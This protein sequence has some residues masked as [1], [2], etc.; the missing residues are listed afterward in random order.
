RGSR[1]HRRVARRDPPLRTRLHA[2]HG[3]AR[4]FRAPLPTASAGKDL[5]QEERR[6][7]RVKLSGQTWTSLGLS[8]LAMG[9]LLVLYLTKNEPGTTEQTERSHNL[10][11]VWRDNEI[12]SVKFVSRGRDFRI[13]RKSASD[14]VLDAPGGEPADGAGGDRPLSGLRPAARR[15]HLEDGDRRALGL[16]KPEVRLEIDTG[17]Q[18]LSLSLG[19]PGPS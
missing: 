1:A 5:A 8:V 2:E 10:V 14:F 19:K 12:R 15:R 4:R 3:S 17:K 13:E 6:R 7:S 11:A 16:D 18:K 9:S